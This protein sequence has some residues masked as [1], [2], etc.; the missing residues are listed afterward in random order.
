MMEVQRHSVQSVRRSDKMFSPEGGGL[1]APPVS[2]G[3]SLGGNGRDNT[4][5]NS[6]LPNTGTYVSPVTSLRTPLPNTTVAGGYEMLPPPM[7]APVIMATTNQDIPAPRVVPVGNGDFMSLSPPGIISGNQAVFLSPSAELPASVPACG[8]GSTPMMAP[9]AP[10]E[11]RPG[12]EVIVSGDFNQ[13]VSRG[14]PS[15]LAAPDNEAATRNLEEQLHMATEPDSLEESKPDHFNIG[16][17]EGGETQVVSES[18]YDSMQPGY[19]S[20]ETPL[21]ETQP[22]NGQDF[23]DMVVL[24]ND[25]LTASSMPMSDEKGG[26]P[27]SLYGPLQIVDTPPLEAPLDVTTSAPSGV[28]ELKVLSNPDKHDMG[29]AIPHINKPSSGE[30]E[31]NSASRDGRNESVLDTE[32]PINGGQAH[33]EEGLDTIDPQVGVLSQGHLSED[34]EKKADASAPTNK[35]NS[36]NPH[37][38]KKQVVTEQDIQEIMGRNVMKKFGSKNYKGEVVEYDSENQWFKVVYEDG[39]QEDLELV[40]VT[41][42]LLVENNIL[43]SSTAKR[44]KPPAKGGA[45][46]VR[47]PKTKSQDIRKPRG[48]PKKKGTTTQTREKLPH[49]VKSS[50][51]SKLKGSKRGASTTLTT[52]AGVETEPNFP[53]KSRG[54]RK[55]S[56]EAETQQ[57]ITRTDA[58]P[59]KGRKTRSSTTKSSIR[60]SPPK[61]RGRKPTQKGSVKAKG[62]KRRSLSNLPAEQNRGKRRHVETFDNLKS[63]VGK[64][65]EKDFDGTLYKGTVMEF[66][67]KSEYYKVKYEDG[68][69][70]DLEFEELKVVLVD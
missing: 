42:I 31:P 44:K 70:E 45:R 22:I 30:A 52:N 18:Q 11:L 68:D 14:I 19:L 56:F 67:S 5:T 3:L 1:S 37:P 28:T 7:G 58:K 38:Q 35:R 23:D 54:K 27:A 36:G 61:K 60:K 10:F 4:N 13:S 65:V 69:Q 64:T 25:A 49:K 53:A 2:T 62:T 12:N 50:Q 20:G 66:D 47:R 40:E 9:N 41:E 32:G 63:L 43:D 39:D 55:R 15:T 33:K 57:E 34:K 21:G 29:R 46:K 24:Q 51:A 26:E 59:K 17:N 48:R 16:Y 6:S 8:F